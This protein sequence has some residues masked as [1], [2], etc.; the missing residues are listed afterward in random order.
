MSNPIF[1]QN[2]KKKNLIK[3]SSAEPAHGMVSVIIIMILLFVYSTII[4]I[5]WTGDRMLTHKYQNREN[6]PKATC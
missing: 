1:W 6:Q 4:F 3:L 2:E 5:A